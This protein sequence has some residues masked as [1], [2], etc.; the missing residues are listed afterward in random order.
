[1]KDCISSRKNRKL[2]SKIPEYLLY[3]EDFQRSKTPIPVGEDNF[4]DFSQPLPS[5]Q[6]IQK[7]PGTAVQPWQLGEKSSAFPPLPVYEQPAVCSARA[8]RVILNEKGVLHPFFFSPDAFPSLCLLE[9]CAPNGSPF[10][11]VLAFLFVFGGG[12]RHL[13]AG[14]YR[15][16]VASSHL[17]GVGFRP[18][19]RVQK[20]ALYSLK[21]RHQSWHQSCSYISTYRLALALQLK[22]HSMARFYKLLPTVGIFI[23]RF[24][25]APHSACRGHCN[26]GM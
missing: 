3:S 10:R 17:L 21:Q 18:Q 9:V 14:S 7:R 23:P 19:H 13:G 26:C 2:S 20:L 22:S 4:F 8:R 25:A 12:Q 6:Y 16:P 5:L 24:C 1:M 15:P 11:G